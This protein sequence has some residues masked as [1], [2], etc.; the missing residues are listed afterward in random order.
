LEAVEDWSEHAGDMWDK[1]VDYAKDARERG[2][3]YV[4]KAAEK[5]APMA[6]ALHRD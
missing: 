4:S 3:D 5:V 6:K 2:A 1:S